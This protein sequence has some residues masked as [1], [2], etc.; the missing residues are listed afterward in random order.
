METNTPTAKQQLLVW[1]VLWFAF[2]SGIGIIY[3]FL[4]RSMPNG[5]TPNELPW[6]IGVVP[7]FI[8]ALIRWVVLP[9]FRTPDQALP[10]F[11]IGIAF[12]E[13][14]TFLGIFIFRSHQQDLFILSVLGIFQF[15]PIFARRFF[16]SAD[17]DRL[18]D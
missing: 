14:S 15:I 1:W 16:E 3:Y 17:Q 12:A 11:V 7:V 4:G 2:Q 18:R 10:W 6:L 9:K 13:T 8:S 5:V